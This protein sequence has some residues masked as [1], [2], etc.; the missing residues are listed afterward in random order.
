VVVASGRFVGNR[1]GVGAIGEFVPGKV[2]GVGAS[3]EF[4]MGAGPACARLT[5]YDVRTR[6]EISRQRFIFFFP[7]D[8]Y[9]SGSVTGFFH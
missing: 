8:S 4:T 5:R 9:R 6:T 2:T 7:Y 1:T 3:G